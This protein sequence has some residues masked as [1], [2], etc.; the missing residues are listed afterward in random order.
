[1]KP[2][3]LVMYEFEAMKETE[4]LAELPLKMNLKYALVVLLKPMRNYKQDVEGK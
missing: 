2:F 3:S 4:C 1:V